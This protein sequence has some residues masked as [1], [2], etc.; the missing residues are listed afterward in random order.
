MASALSLATAARADWRAETGVFRIG[1]VGTGSASIEAERYAPFS[2]AVGEAVGMPA[3][4][5]VMRDAASLIDAQA[6]G[7]IEYAVLSSL[8]YAAAQT[9]CE[10]LVPLAAPRSAQGATGVRSVLVADGTRASGL[11]D[12]RR[13]GLTW[14]PEGSLTGHLLPATAFSVDDVSLTATDIVRDRAPSFEAAAAAFLNGETP[15]LFA[16]DYADADGESD[17]D[18]GLAARLRAQ[19]ERATVVL[20]RSGHVP[21]GPHVVHDAVPVEVQATLSAMLVALDRDRPDAYDAISPALTGG[22]ATVNRA[23]YALAFEIVAA[24]A[25]AR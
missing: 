18:G 4:V 16:W 13:T 12:L 9:M 19:S 1:I 20:W 23:D 22:F 7:R 17:H 14:G 15:A 24:L 2:T 25:E 3:E 10:C 5:I 11:D 21:F 8:G 6:N